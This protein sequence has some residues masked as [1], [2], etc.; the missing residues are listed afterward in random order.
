[1]AHR[2]F[3][4][5]GPV[6]AE[7]FA[8]RLDHDAPSVAHR[9]TEP[10]RA[11]RLA[12]HRT[13][14]AGDTADRH[15]K[16]CPTATQ[17]LPRELRDGGRTH[18]AV[19]LQ[20][21]RTNPEITPLGGIG[22]HHPTG[23]E[24]VR[25]A[26]R[27]GQR[28]GETAAGAGLGCGHRPTPLEQAPD[29]ALQEDLHTRPSIPRARY[30]RRMADHTPV[31]QQYLG[32]KAQHPDTLL[33]YRMGDFYELFFE[34]ARKASQLLDITLTARGQ[35][36]GAP[37]PMAGVPVQSV[38]NYLARLVRKGESVAI[39]EQIGDPAKSKGPVE[40]AVVRVVTPGTVTDAALLDD[41]RE[42]LLAALA[43]GDGTGEDLP[44]GLAW[45][46]LGAGRLSVLEGRGAGALAAELER[47]QPAEILVSESMAEDGSFAA[48][49]PAGK[50]RRR[51]PWH[52]ETE[53]AT[54]ALTA[55]LGTLDLAGY[56][57]SELPL[58]VGAAGALL[59]FVRDTQRTALPHLRALRVEAREAALQ[60]DAVT[61]RNLEIDTSA[62]GREDA[63]LV[64]LLDTTVTAM[65]AR[66]LRRAVNRPLTDRALLQERHAA[67]G[68]LVE[69]RRC[70]ALRAALGPIGDMERMLARIALRTARPRDLTGL[71]LALAALPPLRA[72]LTGSHP[73]LLQ[74]LAAAV[75]EHTTELALLRQ[76]IAEEPAALLRE[77]G[78]IAPGHDAE[79]D[80]LRH[81]ASDTDAFLLE[82]EAR[83]R[84]RTGLPQLK[85]GYNRVQGFFIELPRSQAAEVPPDYLRR[86]TVKN[87][88]RFIT[89]ELKGFEDK[90][91]GARE[92]SLARERVLW[93]ALLE[94]LAAMLP[95]LQDTATAIAELDALAALAERAAT[96]RWVAP[97]LVDR[98]V[99]CI[100]GGRHPV[101]ERF[102]DGPFV[103]N[104][105]TLDA[106]TR[107]WVITG[108]N[109]G[110]KSTFM[111]QAALIVILA[112]I[113]SFVPAN[114]AQIGPLDR[115][116]TRIGAGDDLAGGRSTFMVEM[117]ETANILHNA[118]PRSLV[119]MDEVGRGTSTFDGLALAAATARHLA[120][121]IGAFTLFATHYFELTALAAELPGVINMHLDA[122]E[123][124]DGIVFL[125]AVRPGPASRSYGLAVAQLAG[126]PREVLIE[127]RRTL[128]T[129][130]TAQGA[131]G[132]G[133][134]LGVAAQGR[135]DLAAP[136]ADPVADAVL[137][138]LRNIDPDTLS[139]RDALAKVYDLKKL[140]R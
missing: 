130:E 84:A 114:S 44:F 86:Q 127:A 67:V 28:A 126:V 96:L 14:R 46:D 128:A 62:G 80:E 69:E 139:P 133:A 66:M 59:Q 108:P 104:D 53:A 32:L 26:G 81:I 93:E 73:P 3:A 103:P 65:G 68:A 23:Q 19:A 5:G 38:D 91:L 121:R 48:L 120:A 58:A 45:I 70:D 99:L 83:E 13:A 140:L 21:R 41:R 11:D 118:T 17:G 54:R 6:A 74:R 40:R 35:S 22:V 134:S 55:Q 95:A 20:G 52:F 122:T 124:R 60:I 105:L 25:G 136:I 34:D 135:L 75:G 1:M 16:I 27:F 82:L 49:L 110:G 132:T 29:H 137:S 129:L 98:P 61:R 31:M 71:R 10:D 116:F 12:G 9:E 51:A 119:L 2:R 78:V 101:V 33:F 76:A 7:A 138:A 115:V 87:A 109:M 37:I 90:V 112:H 125:H 57:A 107:M 18:G 24:P 8:L 102:I 79:L 131:A 15:R 64:S 4:H 89:P 30:D 43:L 63:T 113:G 85:L 123:H 50:S 77:G 88:E 117:T 42:V 72:R 39:C 100:R 92:R 111:R 56:G 97:E 94:R 106:A 47:L 36:A